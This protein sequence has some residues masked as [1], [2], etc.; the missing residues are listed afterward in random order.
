MSFPA[1]A[2]AGIRGSIFNK[3]SRFNRTCK[4]R[5]IVYIFGVHMRRVTVSVFRR[6]G[7]LDSLV[8]ILYSD[9]RK[10]RHHKLRLNKRV[11]EFRFADY[12]AYLVADMNTYLFKQ[13]L[14]VAAYTVAAYRCLLYT[15]P[16]PRDRG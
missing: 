7:F 6:N 13:D 2:Y 12:A 5:E 9:Y 3:Y 11:L 1:E 14:R 8:Y 16:S 4:A 15:S 10:Y